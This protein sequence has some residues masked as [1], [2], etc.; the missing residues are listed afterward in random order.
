[1]FLEVWQCFRWGDAC[2]CSHKPYI[3]RNYNH[4]PTFLSLIVWVYVHSHLCSGLQKTHHLFA[5]E[6]V[7]AVQGHSGSSKVDNFGTN[8]KRVCDFLLVINSNF[9]PILHRFRD[10][11]TY[12]LTR[13]TLDCDQ[14]NVYSTRDIFSSISP[15]LHCCHTTNAP[16]YTQLNTLRRLLLILTLHSQT[17]VHLHSIGGS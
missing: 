8:R 2:R 16:H 6:C 3:S 7:L 5:T 12:W 9:G 14:S 4:W 15:N 11:A 10:T 13:N 1:M 17:A